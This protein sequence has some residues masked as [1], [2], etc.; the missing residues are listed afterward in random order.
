MSLVKDVLESIGIGGNVAQ[1]APF[2]SALLSGA[3]DI[4]QRIL[5]N[6]ANRNAWDNYWQR[7]MQTIDMSKQQAP[8]LNIAQAVNAAGDVGE[9]VRQAYEKSL[10]K[11][12]P[13][14]A[15][16]LAAAQLRGT[17]RSALSQPSAIHAATLQAIKTNN[18]GL[19]REA[20]QAARNIGSASAAR[21]IIGQLG[22]Q[23]TGAYANALANAAQAA[24][25]AHDIAGRAFAGAPGIL[26]QSQANQY[27]LWAKPREAQYTSTAS[28]LASRDVVYDQ[29]NRD[30]MINQLIRYLA[31][32]QAGLGTMKLPPNMKE[33]A[34]SP[35]ALLLTADPYKHLS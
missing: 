25:A 16:S 23:S 17:A 12:T 19:R 13:T 10:S 18:E 7:G 31:G 4:L 20:A 29:P 27:N 30:Y 3:A 5:T 1:Q 32:Y 9:G 28:H 34:G 35:D 6:A 33:Q 21:E 8:L 24:A 15:A 22:R 26:E 2:K 14:A 11:V